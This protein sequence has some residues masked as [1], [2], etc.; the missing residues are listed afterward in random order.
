MSKLQR[1][2]FQAALRSLLRWLH[3]AVRKVFRWRSSRARRTK[4]KLA[5][6]RESNVARVRPR[7]G[8]IA[9]AIAVNH[10]IRSHRKSVLVRPAPEQC[11][12]TPALHHPD[13]LGA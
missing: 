2:P 5:A 8:M 10:D 11:V 12:R 4:E 9:R 3:L 1:P 7:L 6:V 13:F